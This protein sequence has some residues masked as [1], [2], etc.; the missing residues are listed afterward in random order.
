MPNHVSYVKKNFAYIT[1]AYMIYC[2]IHVIIG[3]LQRVICHGRH[4]KTWARS[5]NHHCAAWQ[6][7]GMQLHVVGSTVSWAPAN[8]L[9]APPCQ[10][11]EHI[12]E[13]TD[14]PPSLCSEDVL[15]PRVTALTVT[16]TTTTIAVGCR[17]K[18]KA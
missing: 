1:Y 5:Q 14:A 10:L 7:N 12:Q 13:R 15:S 9:P 3:R 11:P 6:V 18:R 16:T 2:I 4:T 17:C 8:A